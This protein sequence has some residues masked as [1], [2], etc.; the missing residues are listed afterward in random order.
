MAAITVRIRKLRPVLIRLRDGVTVTPRWKLYGY[1]GGKCQFTRTYDSLSQARIDAT[2]W[3]SR[4]HVP[5]P[6]NA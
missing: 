4:R 1:A 5:E 3:R 6:I 2:R